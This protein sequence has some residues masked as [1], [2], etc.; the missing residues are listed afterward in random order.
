M[1]ALPTL[2]D[3]ELE[4]ELGGGPLTQVFA[5]RHRQG[6]FRCA[7]K[8]LRPEW[9]ND[10]NAQQLLRREARAGLSA[11][12]R[13]LVKLLDAQVMREPY[14]IVMELL[15]GESLR[16]RLRREYTLEPRIAFW[17]ARQIAEALLALHKIGFVHADI[18]PDNIR[19]LDAGTA[20][21]IDLGFTHRP[22]ENQALARDGYLFATADYLAPELCDLKQDHSYASD[23]FSFGLTL[24]E[25]LTGTRPFASVSPIE[26]LIQHRDIDV[27]PVVRKAARNWQPR[28]AWL[29]ENLLKRKPTD[30]P[31]GAMVLHELTALEIA[32]LSVRRAA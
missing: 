29:V 13:H 21:L 19:M 9:A 31:N 26:T 18:K 24:F 4:K 15:G 1:N 25:M 20:T 14:Y 7:V 12:H 32:A 23:W 3:Y 6:G 17:I 10:A 28:L 16:A 27:T 30:R 11:R 8:L 22:G 5:A 2:P